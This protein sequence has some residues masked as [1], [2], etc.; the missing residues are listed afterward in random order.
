MFRNQKTL[1]EKIVFTGK[2][3]HT[4]R[5]VRLEVRPAAVNTGLVFLRTDSDQA[6]E[7]SAHVNNVSSTELC[8]TIG[9]GPSSIGTIE[10]L[11]AA[12]SGLGI[13]NAFIFVNAPEIP[14]M[15]GSSAP[16]I[17]G[18]LKVGLTD[19][20]TPN[21]LIIVKEAFTY[22]EDDKF[23][24]VEPSSGQEYNFAVDYGNS[25]IGKQSIKFALE[26]MNFLKLADARTF[27]HLKEVTALRAMG[28]AQG[29]SLENAIVVSDNGVMN[30][31]GLRSPDEFVRHKL[32]DLIGD[33]YLLGAQLVAKVTAEKSGHTLHVN[34]L[35][36]ILRQKDRY[37]AVIEPGSF[38]RTK[39][40]VDAELRFAS[41]ALATFG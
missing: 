6:M 36:E 37:L 8:T 3:L 39:I 10:H 12:F 16:F 11:M 9:H 29:G 2:G 19:L 7:I 22:R 35:R 15:D 28:L 40:E 31:E 23:V 41:R 27:C 34:F 20:G 5:Y 38:R 1:K 4:G 18:F 13:D 33:F 25:F 14:I 21:R 26:E 24:T 32:L 17:D 30:E